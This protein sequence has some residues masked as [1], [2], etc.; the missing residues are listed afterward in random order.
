[1]NFRISAISKDEAGEIADLV[2]SAYRGDSSRQGWTTEADLLDGTRVTKD[3]IEETL[4]KGVTILKYAEGG[5]ILGCVELNPDERG[6]YLGM[7]TVSPLFQKR[8]IGM[9]L[10]TAAEDYAKKLSCRSIYMTVI[11]TREELIDWYERRG[12]ADTSERKPF[13]VPDERWGIPKFKLEFTIL[14]RLLI[15]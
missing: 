14:E 12:Y 13:K 4:E 5:A 9:K 11:S 2:N 15:S 7:L 8:G 6:L 1:M 10:L 3:L